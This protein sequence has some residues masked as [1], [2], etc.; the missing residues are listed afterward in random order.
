MTNLVLNEME[1]EDMFILIGPRQIGKTTMLQNLER[2]LKNRGE[3]TL[4]FN[5]DF[6]SDRKFFDSQDI[7][8][9]KI[10]LEIGKRK[11]YIF[12]DEIQRKEN[13]GLFLKGI[14]D[15]K[16]PY[17]WIL[18][19]SGSLELK[20]KIKESL[21]GRKRMYELNPVHFLEFFHYKT[22]YKYLSKE[23][24]AF[25][26]ETEKRDLLFREYLSF[27]GFPRVI[28]DETV[29]EKRRTI[30]EIYT[31]YID[32]D[33]RDLG[34]TKTR[35]FGEMYRILSSRAGQILNYNELSNSLNLSLQ[36]VKQYLWYAE[37]TF[38]IDLCF[39][40]FQNRKKEITKSPIVYFRDIGFMNYS[41]GNFHTDLK[42]TD[43]GFIFQNFIFQHLRE[44]IRYENS[45]LN[46]WRTTD[47]AEVDIILRTPKE[48]IPI[49][50]KYRTFKKPEITRSLRNFI[51]KYKPPTV[52]IV[53]LNYTDIMKL[54][55]TL[56]HF[57]PW[58]RMIRLEF[59]NL[60]NGTV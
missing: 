51:E 40:Y 7:L 35:E 34:I 54:G 60:R 11:A 5:L 14:Y 27:G 16:F 18:S 26:I 12:A 55:E 31:S 39:P 3:K 49:E 20:E 46:Y 45:T 38:Q 24:E 36:T 33:I 4:F 52:W 57:I 6:E 50:V 17:K 23:D 21:A 37:K 32:K 15:K 41:S 53:N 56:V 58:H 29:S 44:K 25:L 59:S 30:E 9:S 48:I 10:E 28:L 1:R 13:A 19:G 43:L 47:G 22:D 2:T 42:S 8:L